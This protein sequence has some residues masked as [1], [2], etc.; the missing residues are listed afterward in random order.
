MRKN[1]IT[2]FLTALAIC[3]AAVPAVSAEDTDKTGFLASLG[4]ANSDLSLQSWQS[5]VQIDEGQN[6]M[7]VTLPADSKGNKGV[8]NGIG[9]LVIDL[10]D[11]YF[12]VGDVSVDKVLIDGKELDFDSGKMIFG[13][14]N[15][16]DNDDYRIELFSVFGAS[17]AE[18]PFDAENITVNDSVEVTFTVTRGG[19]G[20]SAKNICGN[21]ISGR[22]TNSSQP[23][24]GYEVTA[25]LSSDPDAEIYAN[26]GLIDDSFYLTLERG[27]YDITFSSEGYVTREFNEFRIGKKERPDEFQDM[28]LCKCGDVNGD[29]KIN[30]TDISLVAG[31]V[32]QIKPFADDYQTKVADVNRDGKVNVA[33]IT[34][35]AAHVKGLRK[36]F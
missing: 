25:K 13:A 31:Y 3:C 15:G 33:D 30:V 27:I 5:K 26:T 22:K 28:A 7:K 11:C 19:N 32:K 12:E 10:S 8:M 17:A 2:A 1:R 21:V 16:T 18:P 14:D 23:M 20:G 24:K 6:T 34:A 29:N 9:L 35:I 4:L 36:I